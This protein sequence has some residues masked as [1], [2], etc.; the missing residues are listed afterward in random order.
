[1]ENK[2]L[3]FFFHDIDTQK[4]GGKNTLYSLGI[5]AMTF[6]YKIKGTNEIRLKLTA[7]IQEV[8]R[9]TLHTYM[10]DPVHSSCI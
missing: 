4:L 7:Y 10:Y 9:E 2:Q 3:Y 1:M 8:D 6:G 5:V